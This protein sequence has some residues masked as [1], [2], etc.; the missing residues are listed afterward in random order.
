MIKPVRIPMRRKSL[1]PVAE[2]PGIKTVANRD[3][4][5][6]LSIQTLRADS[7]LFQ[8]VIFEDEVVQLFTD[9]VNCHFLCISAARRRA[10]SLYIFEPV[11]HLLGIAYVAIE[12]GVHRLDIDRDRNKF[13]LHPAENLVVPSHPRS[14][15]GP[16]VDVTPNSFDVCVEQVSTILVHQYVCI[17]INI[18]VAITSNMVALLNYN[19]CLVQQGSVPLSKNSPAQS[20]SHD[21]NIPSFVALHSEICL[22]HL[23]IHHCDT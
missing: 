23:S 4:S 21:A 17:M 10:M 20:C 14:M 22:S 11:I 1:V 8:G 9:T 2:V 13:P 7:P 18:I 19:G 15:P 12:Q 3:P 5:R 6:D 16:F